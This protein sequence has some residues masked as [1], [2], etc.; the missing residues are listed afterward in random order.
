MQRRSSVE[1]KKK[2]LSLTTKHEETDKNFEGGGSSSKW[3]G[4][5]ETLSSFIGYKVLKESYHKSF[6]R[7]SSE[8]MEQVSTSQRL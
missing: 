2:K 5:L 7:K 8:K 6:D 3:N 1:D 4:S